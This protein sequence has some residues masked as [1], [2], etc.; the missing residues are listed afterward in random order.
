M[1][2]ELLQEVHNIVS[3]AER[4]KTQIAFWIL[5]V[6]TPLQIFIWFEITSGSHGLDT[7]TK[8]FEIQVTLL[9]VTFFLRATGSSHDVYENCLMTDTDFRRTLSEV[10]IN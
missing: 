8:Y 10:A 1:W 4:F 6:V 5:N 3:F 7:C 2:F 9:N